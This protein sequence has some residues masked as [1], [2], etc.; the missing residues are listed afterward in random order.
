[1]GTKRAGAVLTRW[2]QW[3]A[4][5]EAPRLA[6]E[7]AADGVAAARRA[8]AGQRIESWVTKPLPEGVVR[9][10]P[11]ADNVLDP[12]GLAEALQGAL[13]E[14]AGGE[15]RVAVILPDPVA[16]IWLLPVESLPARPAEAA[17]LLRWRLAKEAAFDL[18]QAVVAYQVFSRGESG[19]A[20]LVAAA[21]RAYLRQYEERFE[22][23]GFEPVWVTL[24]TVSTL[25]WVETE[26][27]AGQL[28]VR[29][30]PN[31]LGLAIVWGS[32]LRLM[33]S[34]PATPREG[35][36]DALFEEIY[37]SLVYFHDE[38]GEPVRE[39]LLVG[40]GE[41]H[42]ELARLLEREAGCRARELRLDSWLGEGAPTEDVARRLAASL[43]F[44][45][46]GGQA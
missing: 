12:A 27:T 22:A 21:H 37:P 41:A 39:A 14:V 6:C 29:C 8:R 16:R 24:A 40:V 2:R 18:E 45:R 23:L 34:V 25:G 30:D 3:L 17:A 31:S 4:G 20:V 46:A 15:K 36:A 13:G 33:R 35:S 19:R 11:L 28:L 9:P 26:P 7:V 5:T 32:E 42:A 10:G 38:W 1:M 43:G 44:L